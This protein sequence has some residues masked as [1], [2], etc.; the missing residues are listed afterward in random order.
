MN[1]NLFWSNVRKILT[2]IPEITITVMSTFNMLSVFSYETLI[3]EIYELKKEFKNDLRYWKT[4]I[5][6]DTSYLRHPQFLSVLLLEEKH[7]KKILKAAERALYLGTP[8]FDNGYHGFSGVEVQKIKR[9][10]DYATQ[11]QIPFEEIKDL[12]KTFATFIKEYDLRKN[13]NFV[14]CFPELKSFYNSNL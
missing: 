1:Y 11:T 5:I 10:Y 4:P 8:K 6:L 13:L 14:E 7:K 9:I 3:N 12:R 2:E